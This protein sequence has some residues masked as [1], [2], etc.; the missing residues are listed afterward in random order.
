MRPSYIL[1][2]KNHIV[3]Y[4]YIIPYRCPTDAFLAIN[5]D[6]GEFAVMVTC[7]VAAVNVP[8]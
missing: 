1:L 3:T 4:L 2:A 6:N 8:C 7:P 5:A